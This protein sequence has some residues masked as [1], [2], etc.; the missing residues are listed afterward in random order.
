M[1]EFR[2]FFDEEADMQTQS[3]E[4]SAD[5]LSKV[6]Q[7]NFT[8]S[9]DKSDSERFPQVDDILERLAVNSRVVGGSSGSAS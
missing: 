8:T 5:T 1:L 6:H 3:M 7:L 2:R 4:T 9:E